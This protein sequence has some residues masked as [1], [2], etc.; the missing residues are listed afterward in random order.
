MAGD[1]KVGVP[2]DGAGWKSGLIT[3]NSWKRRG[4]RVPRQETK[5]AEVRVFAVATIHC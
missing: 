3:G 1:F 5:D 4:R 2:G